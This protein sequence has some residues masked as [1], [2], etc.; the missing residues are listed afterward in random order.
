MH[1]ER[2]DTSIN[3]SDHFTKALNRALFH[4]HA[5]FLLGHVPPMYSPVYHKI[6]GVYTNDTSSYETFV[7]ESFTTPLCAAAA[8]VHAPLP[9]DYADNPWL[10][11]VLYSMVSTIHDDD[12]MNCGGVLQ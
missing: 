7:P 6:V 8:R 2:I 11:I 10:T 12:I 1:L 5:D 4:W 3:M 9:E